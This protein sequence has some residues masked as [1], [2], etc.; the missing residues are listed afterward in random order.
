MISDI[1][2]DGVEGIY[3]YLEEY[4]ERVFTIFDVFPLPFYFYT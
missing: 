4:P 3:K 2:S 1:L